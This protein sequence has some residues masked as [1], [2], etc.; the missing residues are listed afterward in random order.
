MSLQ[1]PLAG[2]TFSLDVSALAGFLGADAALAAMMLPH[3][4]AQRKW[5]GWYNCPGSYYLAKRYGQLARFRFWS[6][7]YR[8]SSVPRELDS[9]LMGASGPRFVCAGSGASIQH[10]SPLA[11]VFLEECDAVAAVE[12][13]GRQSGTTAVAI[14]RFEREPDEL[15]Y[16]RVPR[17]LSQSLALF[18]IAATIVTGLLCG[19]YR[20]HYSAGVIFFS[21]L[22]HGVACL[23]MGNARFTYQHRIPP[24]TASLASGWLEAH[25][26]FAVL[27]GTENAIAPITRGRFSL[28]FNGAKEHRIVRLCSILLGIQFLVQL[29]LMPQGTLFGQTMFI[30]SVVASW[31]YHRL[32]L[33]CGKETVERRV[34]MGDILGG[35][36][37]QKY[38]FGNRTSAAV[39]AA[40]ALR[41]D[42]GVD[43]EARLG[44]LLPNDTSVWTL[45]RR[46]VAQKIL[47]GLPLRFEECDWEWQKLTGGLPTPDESAL[48]RQLLTD[49]EVAY[50]AYS[51]HL[52][53]TDP[54]RPNPC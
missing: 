45:W 37:L 2:L 31:F 21:A 40:L 18:P 4:H 48:F 32:V 9:E 39:F 25:E 5:W 52:S 1:L 51:R 33:A 11:T 44:E 34:L 7:S 53:K 43:I 19:V 23:V 6:P 12:V 17:T 22:S 36:E 50:T 3:I 24:Q 41:H 16:P 8:A 15:E 13:E 28:S 38:R 46:T 35:P 49:A 29:L 30:A 10:T 14:A 20:D 54:P 26:L 27:H 42:I 47:H